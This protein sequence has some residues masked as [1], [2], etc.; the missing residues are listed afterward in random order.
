MDG[1]TAK[2]ML[3]ALAGSNDVERNSVYALYK[4]L[5]ANSQGLPEN[6]IEQIDSWKGK[7]CSIKDTG[8]KGIIQGANRAVGGFYSGITFPV[9]VKITESDDP[10]Y[11]SAIG[12]VFEYS[13][14]QVIMDE[15]N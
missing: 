13:I 9:L 3:E 15:E 1:F 4:E 12:C 14:E 2:T 8:Y 6:I 10:K 7:V 5:K 11:I